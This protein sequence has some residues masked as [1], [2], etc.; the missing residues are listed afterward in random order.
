MDYSNIGIYKLKKSRASCSSHFE[1]IYYS[2]DKE[3][4]NMGKTDDFIKHEIIG[5]M[6]N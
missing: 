3:N 1:V 6:N 2:Q 5:E 4:I